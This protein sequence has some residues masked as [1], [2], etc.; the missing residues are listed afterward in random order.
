MSCGATRADDANA[1]FVV[2]HWVGMNDDQKG[3]R[4]DGADRVSPLFAFH[5][6]VRQNDVERIVPDFLGQFERHGV[7]REFRSGLGLVPFK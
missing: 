2:S 6:P 1:V 4:A 7:F 3:C 5:D